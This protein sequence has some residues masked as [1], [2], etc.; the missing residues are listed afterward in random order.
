MKFKVF[1]LF[2]F[3]SNLIYSQDKIFP[4]AANGDIEFSEVIEISN[5]KNI[6]YAN[7]KE[8]VAKT[9]GD[10][11]E[12]IQFED[13]NDG[14]LIMKGKSDVSS[15][16]SG[17]N[18]SLSFTITIECKDKKYRY[19]INDILVH[20]TIMFAGTPIHPVP[21]S[22][23]QHLESKKSFEKEKESLL[24]KDVS[25]MK[26]KALMEH[27]DKITIL[28]NSIKNEQYEYD[29]EYDAVNAIINSLKYA[30]SQNNEF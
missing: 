3:I 20:Q 19:R 6:L 8:W 12:V 7:A 18:K 2:I 15:E 30:M 11:K 21:S 4:V 1:F 14:K 13:A 29:K 26:K 25:R 22:P 17:S 5:T 10:Y 16:S 24:S 27:Q 9:F 23:L 28:E